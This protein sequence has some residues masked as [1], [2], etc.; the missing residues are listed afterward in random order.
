MLLSLKKI[1]GFGFIPT[2]KNI[3]FSTLEYEKILLQV[4]CSFIGFILSGRPFIQITVNVY[5]F[6]LRSAN[7]IIRSQNSSNYLPKEHEKRD[8]QREVPSPT[9]RNRMNTSRHEGSSVPSLE[10]VSY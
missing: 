1:Y 4:I 3:N 9:E 8:E 5:R 2:S 7:Q 6:R 10:I